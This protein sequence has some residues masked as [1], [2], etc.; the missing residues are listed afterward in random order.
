MI[1]VVDDE[2]ESRRLLTAILI[3]EGYT[4]RAAD[5]GQLALASRTLRR[6]E[7]ILLDIRMPGMDGFEVC[8]RLKE[9]P[10]TRDIPLMFLTASAEIWEKVEG[11]RLGAVDFVSKPYRREELLARVRTHL[12]LG[13]LRAHLEEQVAERTAKLRESEERFRN[14]ADAAPVMIWIAGP[15]KGCTFFNRAWIEFTGRTVEQE[16]GSGWAEGVHPEDQNRCWDVYSTSFDARRS[17]QMEYRLRRVDGQY[18]WV[19]DTG[20][21]RFEPCGDFLGY[22][23]SCIDITDFK[24]AQEEHLAKQKLETVGALAGGIVHDFGNLLGGILAQAELA[25]ADLPARSTAGEQL[26]KI[27][28]AAIRGAGISRQLMIYAGAESEVLELINVSDIVESMLDLLKLSVSRNVVLETH[29]DKQLRA[30]RGNSSQIQRVVMN[31]ITNASEAIGDR[32]GVIRVATRQVKVGSESPAYQGITPGDYVELEVSDTGR[33]MPPEVLARIFDMSFTTKTSGVHGLGLAAVHG[34]VERHHAFIR[35]SS[36]PGKG[37]TFGI[38]LP[39]EEQMVEAPHNAIPTAEEESL[40]PLGGTILVVEDDGLLRRAFSTTLRRKGFS[41]LEAS[42][43]SQALDLLRAQKDHIDVLLMDIT[44]PGAPSREVYEEARLLRPDLPIIVT[45][46]CS[47]EMAAASLGRT[48]E[49]FIRKPFG[50]GELIEMVRKVS[51]S[52]CVHAH[53]KGTARS[54]SRTS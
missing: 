33:G 36:T 39:C 2:A 3:A 50:L 43:G 5:G 17:F 31:L 46:A 4:V 18:R 47:K 21:P 41:V 29:F 11:F 12:E 40:A 51:F 28:D 45:S 32:E 22:I 52:D 7:L 25:L 53:D 16:L 14:M 20:V 13:K 15:D 27:R 26:Q 10:E 24:R 54:H 48:V 44:L 34:I 6:P 35:L 38:L 9:N 1:L 42:D 37:S 30:V 19:L 49:F 23:G 8:R